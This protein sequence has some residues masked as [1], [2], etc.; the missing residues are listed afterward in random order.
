MKIGQRKF[1]KFTLKDQSELFVL[2]D[3]IDYIRWE[4]DNIVCVIT[5]NNKYELDEEK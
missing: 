5:V 1:R 3:D 4:N 2:E